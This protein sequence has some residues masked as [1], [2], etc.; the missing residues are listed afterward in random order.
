MINR[1]LRKIFIRSFEQKRKYLIKHGSKI[2][3]NTR[4]LSDIDSFGS[5]PYLIEIGDKCLISRDVLFLTHDGGITVLNNLNLFEKRMD[6]LSRII[7]GNN[8]FIGA[9]SIIMPGVTIGN[10]V[11]IGAGSIVT[12]DVD[13]NCVIC[14]VPAKKI[15]SIDDYFNDMKEK[16]YPTAGMSESEKCEYCRDNV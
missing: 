14:G 12:K 8:C 3:S 11:I 9:R 7:I 15:K 13:D 2:G 10:N 16:V 1:I 4:I 6:K 5:E